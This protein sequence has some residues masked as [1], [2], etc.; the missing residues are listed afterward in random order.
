LKAGEE[1]I[2]ASRIES[3]GQIRHIVA[4]QSPSGTSEDLD[5]LRG[6]IPNSDVIIVGVPT[7]TEVSILELI[8]KRD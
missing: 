5:K 8:P 6:L 3:K 1:Q 4:I 7:G 2:I